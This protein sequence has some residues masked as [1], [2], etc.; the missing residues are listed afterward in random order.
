LIEARIARQ[1]IDRVYPGLPADVHFDACSSRTF[2]PVVSGQVAVVSADA[3]TDARSGAP[4][5]TLRVSVSPQEV[6][7]LG[8][9]QLLPGMQSTVIVKTGERTLMVY[10]TR[11]PLR[12]FTSALS[13]H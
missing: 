9:L 6:K 2:Q 11:P 3:L 10:L 13:E 5:Y 8:K 1:Y 4:Y 7:K 12:R